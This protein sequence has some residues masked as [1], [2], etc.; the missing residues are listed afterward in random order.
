VLV[1]V[2][3]LR[4]DH[5][6]VYGDGR[7]LSPAIDA[8][9]S[10]AALFERA[11]APASFTT[12]SLAS[13][14]TS[15][16][17]QEVGVFDN[18]GVPRG[19]TPMMA[20]WLHGHGWDTAAVVSSYVL[21]KGSG[22]TRGFERYDARLLGREAARPVPER[23]ASETTDAAL[24][25]L[26]AMA[27]D[28]P[29]F[30][31]V[32]YQD[33]HGPYTPPEPYRARF[34]SAEEARPDGGR[35]LALSPSQSGQGAIPR[36][37]F[38]GRHDAAFYRAGYAGEVAF[39][40]GSIGKLVEGLRQRGVL[41]RALLVLTADHGEGLGED[42]YW[43]AHGER[44]E[45][46]LVRVPLVIRTPRAGGSRRRDTASLLDVL[47]TAAAWFKVPLPEGARG[48]DLLAPGADAASSTLLMSTLNMTVPP[49]VAVVAEGHHYVGPAGPGAPER[50][51]A[52]GSPG[53]DLAGL[54]PALVVKLR[55]E[56]GA[57]ASRLPTVAAAAPA[58]TEEQRERLRALGYVSPR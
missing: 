49:R 5:L 32:H 52:A 2:D 4:A 8:L 46:P 11:Y 30:L 16:Y 47:P 3:T 10:R 39:L 7:G 1:T 13:L 25:M 14:L 51:F 41:D 58:L 56:A 9:A 38:L 24:A 55:E 19:E 31:W 27:A 33:T 50:L 20:Q 22:F 42:D 34:L 57:L 45:E 43:F 23:I 37:Q 21:R 18:G 15:R 35:V 12:A 48:R 29:R 54:T 28:R 36:Y 26:D 40:D 53:P 6:G 44:L 17:P